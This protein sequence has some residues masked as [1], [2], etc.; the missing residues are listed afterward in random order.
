MYLAA[1]SFDT[2]LKNVWCVCSGSQSKLWQSTWHWSL[3]AP[4]SPSLSLSPACLLNKWND[5]CLTFC[6][7]W[8]YTTEWAWLTHKLKGR[9]PFIKA[10]KKKNTWR[11]I[12]HLVRLPAACYHHWVSSHCIFFTFSQWIFHFIIVNALKWNVK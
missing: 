5:A 2:Q 3:H 6:S 1:S 11:D 10:K 9:K 8:D 4:L 7:V 12:K